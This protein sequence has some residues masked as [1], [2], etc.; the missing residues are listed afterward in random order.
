MTIL[1]GTPYARQARVITATLVQKPR[2][3]DQIDVYLE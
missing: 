2:A 3:A 1:P